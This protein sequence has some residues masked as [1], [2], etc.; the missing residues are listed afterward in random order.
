MDANGNRDPRLCPEMKED[1]SLCAAYRV[2]GSDKC[3][4]H[5]PEC[6]DAAQAA[7]EKGGRKSKD[8]GRPPL[9]TEEITVSTLDDVLAVLNKVVNLGLK[10]LLDTKLGNMLILACQ[11]ME[12]VIEARDEVHIRE[13]VARLREVLRQAQLAQGRPVVLPAPPVYQIA[14]NGSGQ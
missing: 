3:F 11:A 13:E 1:G 8:G 4:W 6:R 7:R 9:I 5:D 10:G 12:K 14:H 2:K